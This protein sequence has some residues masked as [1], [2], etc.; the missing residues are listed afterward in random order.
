M[1]RNTTLRSCR[2]PRGHAPPLSACI[3]VLC[4]VL[5]P[6]RPVSAVSQGE[7]IVVV[8]GVGVGI[9]CCLGL[10]YQCGHGLL[11][12]I[13][14][15]CCGRQT[16]VV[17]VKEWRHDHQEMLVEP[18]E[19]VFKKHL[20]IGWWDEDGDRLDRED[21]EEYGA[22][23]DD[24][25]VK[26]NKRT[27]I[28]TVSLHIEGRHRRPI[29]VTTNRPLAQAT[30]ET[31]RYVWF[32]ARIES[33]DPGSQFA[34]GWST[35]PYPPAA[36]P[37]FAPHSVA[38]MWSGDNLVPRTRNL[39]GKI[40]DLHLDTRKKLLL[41]SSDDRTSGTVLD[42]LE[43]VP[44]DVI[45]VGYKQVLEDRGAG[46]G[47]EKDDSSTKES[48]MMLQFEF[49]VNGQRLNIPPHLTRKLA[50]NSLWDADA[51]RL[52]V[53][54][55]KH[56]STGILANGCACPVF[57]GVGA[58]EFKVRLH[59]P[60]DYFE[61]AASQY[62][63]NVVPRRRSLAEAHSLKVE[64]APKLAARDDRRESRRQMTAS[65][66]K[67]KTSAAVAPAPSDVVGEIVPD[68]DAAPVEVIR[69]RPPVEAVATKEGEDDAK[70]TEDEEEEEV[71]PQ[72]E[73]DSSD[74]SVDSAAGMHITNSP[75][76]LPEDVQHI[77]TP[78]AMMLRKEAESMRGLE[79]DMS[80]G[81][82]VRVATKGVTAEDIINAR[83]ARAGLAY[84]AA[85]QIRP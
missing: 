36:M 54:S 48:V 3:A 34:V 38:L 10:M 83:A 82:G 14:I 20:H 21:G 62:Q 72:H 61:Q 65:R 16:K 25:M 5:L 27:D 11:A 66:R 44:G 12:S 55:G 57:G 56:A 85:A 24:W 70:A 6:V 76:V 19:G 74:E 32:E 35:L 28:Y 58:V 53:L 8:L 49:R 4:A 18:K 77:P 79:T 73:A 47:K 60:F 22:D 71:P 50:V 30:P 26:R 81:H 75:Q 33:A 43:L 31:D 68:P 67:S 13:Y 2:R 23:P 52:Q 69:V 51:A 15:C 59:E 37:G 46:R 39:D 9:L 29:A 1:L 40:R 84:G 63:G 7:S 41:V 64:V 80:A 17:D 45:G 78:Q 42:E